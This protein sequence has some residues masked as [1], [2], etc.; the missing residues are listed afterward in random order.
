MSLEPYIREAFPDGLRYNEAA[1]LCLRLY[2]SVEGI[3]EELHG[4]CSKDGLAEVFARLAATGL[5]T[6]EPLFAALYGANF[7]KVKE[8]GHWVEVI[9]SLFKKG[10]TRDMELGE[11]VVN[12]LTISFIRRP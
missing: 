6:D 9:A 8:K 5:L 10:N 12:R 2:C 11:A 3:P 1:Q 7:H 4:E